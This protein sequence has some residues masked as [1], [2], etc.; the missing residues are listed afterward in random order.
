M[1]VAALLTDLR[2]RGIELR[3][4]G[5]RLHYS[6]PRGALTADLRSQLAEHR[7]EL[8][9][10]LTHGRRSDRPAGLAIEAGLSRSR[11]GRA[12]SPDPATPADSH[13]YVRHVNPYL[14]SWLARLDLDK[15]FV[16][17]EGC[18]LYDAQG[19]RYLDFIAQYGAVPFGYNPPE[20]WNAL[21][22]VRRAGLPSFVQPSIQTSAGE[23]AE[24][25][26]RL[27]P[28]GLR[29]VTFANS[30]A[31]AVE[32]AIKLCRSATGRP[33]ILAAQQSYHGKTLGAMS[34][35]GN[36]WYQEPFGPPL[37]DFHHVPFGDVDA[38]SRAFRDR[39]GFYAALL[40]EP[41]QGEGGM[42]EPPQGYLGRARELCDQSGTLLI[43]DEVQTGLG[44]TGTLFACEHEGVAPDVMTLAK[45]LGG[46]LVPI[47]ACL[48]TEEV[49]NP[50]FALLHSSTFAGNAL[51]CRAGLATLDLLERDEQ[52]MVRHVSENGR[53][54]K[55]ELLDLQR[56][57]PGLIKAVRGRGYM[58]GVELDADGPAVRDGLLGYLTDQNLLTYLV[59]SHLLNVE[60]VRV[61]PTASAENVLRIEPPL[62]VEW[63][64]CRVFLDALD[65]T[66]N[67]LAHGDTARLVGHLAGAP[68]ASRPA[69]PALGSSAPRSGS[70][71]TLAAEAGAADSRFAFIVH[72]TDLADFADLDPSLE[73]FDEEQLRS[74]R[75]RGA[76]LLAPAPIGEALI[77]S[78]TGRTAYGRFIAVPFTARE[79]MDMPREAA[80]SE[81]GRAV[82]IALE[83]GAQIVGLGGFT[84][85]VT[86]GGLALKELGLGPLT[87]GNSYTV[88]AARRGLQMA[89]DQVGRQLSESC[90]AVLGA[91]G[92]IGRTVSLLL[93][94]DVQELIL[95]GNPAYAERSRRRLL[96]VA[97][98]ILEHLWDLHT[99]NRQ[100]FGPDTVAASLVS[101]IERLP[102]RPTSSD[103]VKLAEEIETSP[104]SLTITTDLRGRLPQAD[105][106]VTAT[107][108]VEG[109]LEADCL[110][111]GS[112]VCEI[113]RPFNATA[114]VRSARPDVLF[115][116]AGLVRAPSA[117][118]LGRG[119]GHRSGS[120]FACMAETM[121]LALEGRYQDTSLGPDLDLDQIREF[122][123]LGDRHG[124]S[125][126]Y[127]RQGTPFR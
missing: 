86:L 124:F 47:G 14:A 15:Q 72:L 29:Y 13:P 12:A 52:R 83:G 64:H 65:R 7:P 45:A 38:L 104:G 58:L 36:S 35:T 19:G 54:L 23:L 34:A 103:L 67:A 6:A 44:R 30:G 25:L 113:S 24:R 75:E 80:L 9:A 76:G 97:A 85:V 108:A 93:A 39:K 57:Y 105:L 73:A 96:E 1:S 20:I 121:L 61:A 106:T 27:A 60:K 125:V 122:D 119:T 117:S 41:I 77:E 84:S 43:L 116:E 18:Y 126:E 109:L 127:G 114:E 115:M 110:K 62:T 26:V 107:S 91:T 16:R 70:Q 123:A 81:V 88:A 4:E 102:G 10:A 68:E 95:I 8:L 94:E 78:R 118:K 71:K 42:V 99:R 31:E 28:P 37:D 46:G 51:A 98:G 50:D 56:K 101:L 49:Y 32:A 59:T 74:L 3:A 87:T 11:T 5:G 21:E 82:E 53:D 48:C 100:A 111:Q 90:V 40:L 22:Q 69:A 66:L 112:V 55:Q 79:L 63:S 89:C 2:R 92:A 17:G 33:G 120:V